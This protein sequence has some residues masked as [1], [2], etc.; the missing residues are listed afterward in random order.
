[1]PPLRRNN[2]WWWRQHILPGGY[3]VI[4]PDGVDR[5]RVNWETLKE[6]EDD[7][8]Y[9]NVIKRSCLTWCDDPAF[10][11]PYGDICPGGIHTVRPRG[12]K[13]PELELAWS[14]GWYDREPIIQWI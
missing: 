8:K 9:F 4:C 2:R 3:A 5:L 11:Y 7:A 13:E 10:K 6:A 14:T 12:T 1:M